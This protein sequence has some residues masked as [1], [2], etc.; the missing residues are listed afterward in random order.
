MKIKFITILLLVSFA[1]LTGVAA[2]SEE[3]F[4]PEAYIKEQKQL[5]HDGIKNA[6]DKL[7]TASKNRKKEI[8]ASVNTYVKSI[9]KVK[10][11][12]SGKGNLEK[13]LKYK[14]LL[15]K[16]PKVSQGDDAFESNPEEDEKAINEINKSP[17]KYLLN[18]KLLSEKKIRKANRQLKIAKN[19]CKKEVDSA[20]ANYD[21]AL[22]K[23]KVYYT[24]LENIEK[25]LVYKNIQEEFRMMPY[26]NILNIN[27]KPVAVDESETAPEVDITFN[28]TDSVVD[29]SKSDNIATED[30]NTVEEDPITFDFT[31]EKTEPE[32]PENKTEKVEDNREIESN[33]IADTINLDLEEVCNSL[34]FN[35]QSLKDHGFAVNS[36]CIKG[37]L[38]EGNETPFISKTT[39]KFNG[40]C[41]YCFKI[42]GRWYHGGFLKIDDK[43]YYLSFGHWANNGARIITN[44]HLEETKNGAKISAN[45]Q[46]ETK[47]KGREYKVDRYSKDWGEVKIVID[48]GNVSYLYNGKELHK[49]SVN[50]PNGAQLQFGFS[51]YR[52]ET[53]LKDFSLKL[54]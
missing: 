22:E 27:K 12:W 34:L 5:F 13:V 33:A 15:E 8:Q 41:E 17:Q 2:D 26:D 32:I 31:E 3:N 19:N 18:Q 49:E 54:K 28:P 39:Y 14:K 45:E 23:V 11:Y 4:N 48:N 36:S 29:N 44:G 16:M 46:E 37:P 20:I 30:N 50:I 7:D 52:C 10:K 40:K 35:D 42:K 47:L 51:T 53:E 43:I 6:N 21:S 25:A 24:K 38:I 1:K 9:Q